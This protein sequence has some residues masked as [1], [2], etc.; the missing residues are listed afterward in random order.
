MTFEAEHDHHDPETLRVE[1]VFDGPDGRRLII[2]A[3]WNGEKEWRARFAPTTPGPWS[4]A[5]RSEVQEDEGLNQPAGVIQCT[6]YEGEL[7]V[8]RHGFVRVADHRRGFVYDDGTPF[9]WLGDTH[10]QA[11]NYERLDETNHPHYPTKGQFAT[12]VCAFQAQG[13][14]VYQTY[15]DA[16]VNDGGGNRSQAEWWSH[17]YSQINPRAFA[18]QFDPMMEYLAERG[19]VIALGIGVHWANG[20]IGAAAM[21]R[22]A[23]HLVARYSCYPVVWLTGQEVDVENGLDTLPV[24]HAV[25]ET[26]HEDDGYR[27]P[28]TAHMDS[29]G[30]PTTFAGEQWH[31]WFATQGGHGRLRSRQHYAAYWT[32][33]PTKPFLETEANYEGILDVRPGDARRSAWRAVQCGSQGFTYG[34]AGTWAMKWAPDEPGWDDYQNGTVWYEGLELPERQQMVHLRVFYESLKNW[35]Q[36]T[37]QFDGEEHGSFEDAEATL[38]ST[39]ANQIYVVYSSGEGSGT[40][41]LKGM[42]PRAVY[43][44]RWY[45]PRTGE[46]YMI[47]DH[48]TAPRG[49]WT[50]PDRPDTQDWTLLVEQVL[51]PDARSA[52]Q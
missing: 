4:C 9:F 43:S 45:D 13:F 38:L 29:V 48:L 47:S 51:D 11:P 28:L 22:F 15:P 25:A 21:A 37:P 40:G 30:E 12:S 35:Q 50:I 42:E 36:L 39:I 52:A 10:W 17:R 5:I 26:I 32:R 31:D 7:E 27:H 23:R 24:W 19:I 18:A 41:V 8:Y 44:A 49:Q 20:R 1:A 34:G 2:P 6:A 14:T 3:W 33:E 46:W 16:A